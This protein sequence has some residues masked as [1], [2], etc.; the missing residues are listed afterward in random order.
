[1]NKTYDANFPITPYIHITHIRA[2]LQQGL[3]NSIKSLF[4]KFDSRRKCRLGDLRLLHNVKAVHRAF[5]L[6]ERDLDTCLT[7][8]FGLQNT[9]IM[10]TIE[11]RRFNIGRR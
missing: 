3:T 2:S 7:K 6:I 9:V 4:H 11:L 8:L 5:G 1:M 10:K